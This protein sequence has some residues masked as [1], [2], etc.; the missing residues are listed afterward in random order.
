[1]LHVAIFLSAE[2]PVVN[3]PFSNLFCSEGSNQWLPLDTA[4]SFHG[5]LPPYCDTLEV[6]N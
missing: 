1:M 5:I 6:K 4:F 3:P 2:K